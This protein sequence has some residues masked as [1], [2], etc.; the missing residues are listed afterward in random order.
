MNYLVIAVIAYFLVA[1]EVILDK[2]LLTSKRVSHPSIYAFYIGMMSL[3]ALGFIP[4]GVHPISLQQAILMIIPGIIFTYGVMSLFFAIN[5]SEA[6]RVMPVVGAIIPIATF[7]LSIFFLSEKLRVI[8]LVGVGALIVGGLLI[9]FEFPF[10]DKKRFFHGFYYSI[11]A[12]ILLAIAFTWFKYFFEHDNF[13]NVFVWTRI[14]LFFGALSL[15]LNPVWRKRILESFGGFK[16]PQKE[17]YE[18]GSLFVV[19]KAL[20]G[21]GSFMTN[22]AIA[23]GSVTIVN[24]LVSTEYVFILLIGLVMSL[25]FPKIFQE[26]ESALEITQKVVSI[27]IISLGVILI[28]LKHRL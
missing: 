1:I 17:H 11:A 5:K 14:G 9:S 3:F 12:G 18:T 27:I 22:F 10:K 19:N 15:F 8:Q 20:G 25:K 4:F 2:F 16:K 21:I 6:S 24:A 28:S 13:V 23:I 26:K 7:L